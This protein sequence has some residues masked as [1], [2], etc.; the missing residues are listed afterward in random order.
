MNFCSVSRCAFWKGIFLNEKLAINPIKRPCFMLEDRAF[1]ISLRQL[2]ALNQQ[3]ASF[4]EQF[5]FE[6]YEVNTFRPTSGIKL[7]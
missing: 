1:C 5:I 2:L 3:A 7:E 4:K 6:Y